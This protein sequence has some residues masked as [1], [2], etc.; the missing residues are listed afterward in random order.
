MYSS[1]SRRET[2]FPQPELP[3]VV[4]SI[5]ASSVPRKV[6]TTSFEP[7]PGL[8]SPRLGYSATNR[9]E[10]KRTTIDVGGLS[11]A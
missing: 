9:I 11:R 4:V 1:S 8:A 5:S 10:P 2:L 6:R 7:Q 3:Q